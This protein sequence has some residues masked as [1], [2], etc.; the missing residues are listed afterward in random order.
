MGSLPFL[1]GT[2]WLMAMPAQFDKAESVF[3]FSVSDIH[4]LVVQLGSDFRWPPFKQF[5]PEPGLGIFRNTSEAAVAVRNKTKNTHLTSPTWNKQYLSQF[6]THLNHH[7]KEKLLKYLQLLTSGLWVTYQ[8]P[9]LF[10][11]FIS[12][13]AVSNQFPGCELWALLFPGDC[14]PSLSVS[15]HWPCGRKSR[16]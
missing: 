7:L 6:H 3:P 15:L 8:V 9:G 4:K 16:S 12:S 13:A 11:S 14:G 2:C 5:L 1:E 10:C